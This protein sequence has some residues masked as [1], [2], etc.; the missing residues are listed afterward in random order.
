MCNSRMESGLNGPFPG[1]FQVGF[2]ES[3]MF[4][5]V[6]AQRKL[7]PGVFI[8]QFCN[9]KEELHLL[10][11][12]RHIWSHRKGKYS[13]KWGRKDS[14]TSSSEDGT[15]L[16]AE[17]HP[18]HGYSTLKMKVFFIKTLTCARLGTLTQRF[19]CSGPGP[20]GPPPRRTLGRSRGCRPT[21]WSS[22]GK[23]RTASPSLWCLRAQQ[24]FLSNC[25]DLCRSPGGGGVQ[26]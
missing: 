25:W 26:I 23:N 18:K 5:Q 9:N 11:L 3:C 14:E 21:R 10:M 2:K 12:S 8:W 1:G 7:R 4:H 17:A 19:P 20:P 22:W 16:K 24:C 13:I 15:C 6:K